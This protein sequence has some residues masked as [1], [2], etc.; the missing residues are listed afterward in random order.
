[1]LPASATG[2]PARASICAIQVVVVDFPLVPV[3][4]IHRFL[5]GASASAIR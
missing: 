1:M 2:R 3:T 4:A 5:P